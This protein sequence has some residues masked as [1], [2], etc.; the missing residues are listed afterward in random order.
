[1]VTEGKVGGEING[2]LRSQHIHTN[3]YKI[4]L[5][6]WCSGKESACQYRRCQ[7]HGFDPWVKMTHWS[8][9]WQPTPVFLLGKFHGQGCLAGYSP[10]DHKESDIT[11]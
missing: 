8:R 3:I 7:R 6:R 5:P 2:R 4:G 1:M 10:W 9:K 11:E